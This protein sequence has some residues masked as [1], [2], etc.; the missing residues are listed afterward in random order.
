MWKASSGWWHNSFS[1]RRIVG[2]S[3][4][5]RAFSDCEEALCVILFAASKSHKHI[6]NMTRSALISF[7][8]ETWG[9]HSC[10]RNLIKENRLKR[11]NGEP[12][13]ASTLDLH[14]GSECKLHSIEA[15]EDQLHVVVTWHKASRLNRKKMWSCRKKNRWLTILIFDLPSG[16]RY[17]V[18]SGVGHGFVLKWLVAVKT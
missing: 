11:C 17:Q 18:L 13:P 8:V 12:R 1:S 2:C 15:K 16:T 9:D 7:N 5:Q 4:M 6:E 14:R 3:G 10:S